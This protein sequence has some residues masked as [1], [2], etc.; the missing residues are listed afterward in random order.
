MKKFYSIVKLS[1]HVVTEDSVAIGIVFFD[2]NDFRTYFSQHKIKVAVKLNR[3][4]SVNI[5]QITQ[6]ITLKCEQLN[7]NNSKDLLINEAQS[8]EQPSYFHYL[9]RYANGLIQFSSPNAFVGEMND[10]LFSK[11]ILNLFNDD[12]ELKEEKK[13]NV[14]SKHKTIIEKNLIRLV[15]NKIHTYYNFNP[16][17]AEDIYFSLEMDCIGKNGALIGAKSLS[18]EKSRA[19][20]DTHLSHYFALIVTLSNRYDLNPR[21]NSFYM[22]SEEPKI[23]GSSTHKIWEVVKKHELIKMIHPEEAGL[24]ANHILEKKATTFLAD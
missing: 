17:T 5:K 21:E 23:V 11:F 2:G 1:P 16:T 8:Y 4:L 13:I 6:D 24:V 22:I 14:E 9:S 3:S 19:T 18:F 7:Q 20:I 10:R 15:E 12:I